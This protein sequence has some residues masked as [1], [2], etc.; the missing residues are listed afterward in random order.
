MMVVMPV[1]MIA[2]WAWNMGPVGMHGASQNDTR[3]K[4]ITMNFRQEEWSDH[5][6]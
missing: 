5:D 6:S 1:M 3:A 4:P 2:V